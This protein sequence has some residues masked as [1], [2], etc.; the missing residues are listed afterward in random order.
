[1][2]WS[3]MGWCL[4]AWDGNLCLCMHFVFCIHVFASVCVSTLHVCMQAYYV[5][6]CMCVLIGVYV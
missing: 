5:R 3:G 6:A 4:D 2:V 1:M